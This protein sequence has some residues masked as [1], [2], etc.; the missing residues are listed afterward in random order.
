MTDFGLLQQHGLASAGLCHT[1]E[2]TAPYVRSNGVDDPSPSHVAA[3]GQPQSAL[4]P[5]DCRWLASRRFDT[6]QPPERLMRLLIATDAWH[7]QVNGVVRTLM[8]L[9]KSVRRQ[10]VAVE[11]LTPEGFPSIPVPT[12]PGLRLALPNPREIARRIER[13][14]PNAIHIATEGPIGHIGAALLRQARIAV[15]DQL[16]DALSRVHH[17]RASR[18]P[19]AGPTRRCGASMAP[20]RS[21]WY[22]RRSL[23]AELASRGFDESRAVDAR[24]RHRS[25]RARARDRSRPAAARSSSASAASRSRKTSRL[26]S[27]SICPAPR[28]SSAHG[29]QEAELRARFP[30]ANS[31]AH[32][33]RRRSLPIWPPPTS[34][35]FR[36]RPTPSA[37]CS[38]RRWP[39]ACRSPPIRSRAPRTSSAAQPDRRAQR[40]PARS[41]SRRA[42]VVAAPCRAFALDNTWENSARQF[43]GHASAVFTGSLRSGPAPACEAAGAP[44]LLPSAAATRGAGGSHIVASSITVEMWV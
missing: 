15:H 16:Y 31:S 6:T 20:P 44:T 24:R 42:A 36:A 34:S 22:P 43:L 18:S 4:P 3:A 41:L 38:S 5:A 37:S 39:P 1:I 13:A 32:G 23:M 33:G 14:A 28:W 19:S 7:P 9:A 17:A 12:Y 21:R 27:R 29:P 25:V 2:I 40:R 11:F 35:C 30:D 8:S 26:S 10:G